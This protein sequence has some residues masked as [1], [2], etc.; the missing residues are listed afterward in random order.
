MSR[1]RRGIA[2]PVVLAVLVAL[3]LLSALALSDATRDWR[4]ATLAEDAVRSR[5]AA[6]E[7]LLAVGS[8][9]NLQ[10][11]CMTGPLA[12]QTRVLAGPSG[13]T[14]VVVW[15]GFGPGL[16]RAEIEGRGRQGARHRLYAMLR[17]DSAERAM[18]LFRCPGA[19]R[20]LPVPG[21][22]LDGHPEG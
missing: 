17:P 3:G 10:L 15:R 5:A 9:P 22:W 19:T 12:M 18:G 8:P 13:T 14:A 20:L 6:L 4:V 21:R 7:A 2:L 11:V 1:V 16:I